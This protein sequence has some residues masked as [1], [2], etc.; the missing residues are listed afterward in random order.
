MLSDDIAHSLATKK[1]LKEEE[2]PATELAAS[3][4]RRKTLPDLLHPGHK[5][6]SLTTSSSANGEKFHHR[7]FSLPVVQL[8]H[9]PIDCNST[10]VDD[11]AAANKK[12][13]HSLD[14]LPHTSYC[15]DQ[16]KS[17]QLSQLG[18]FN[19]EDQNLYI[20]KQ[21]RTKPSNV[22]CSLSKPYRVEDQLKENP[23]ILEESQTDGLET[24]NFFRPR[25]NSGNN[26]ES[27]KL[28]RNTTPLSPTP[29]NKTSRTMPTSIVTRL[30][31]PFKDEQRKAVLC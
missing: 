24:S 28:S 16:T 18:I 7:T 11:N 12:S 8:T 4:S 22:E 23:K 6:T 17:S 10:F 9:F 5:E 21:H 15:E 31:A 2:I 26:G 30:K 27:V 20:V 13:S 19:V 3:A 25:Y 14:D 29:L 1:D